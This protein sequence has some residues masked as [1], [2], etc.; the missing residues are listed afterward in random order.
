M[1]CVWPVFAQTTFSLDEKSLLSFGKEKAPQW[2]AIEATFL[3]AKAEALALNDRFRPELFGEAQYSETRERAIIQFMPVW[4]PTES[5][6]VG[7]RQAFRGGVSASAAVGADQRSAMSP[8]GSYRDVSTSTLRL[9]VSIDLWKDLFGKLSKAQSDSANFSAKRAELERD[10][11]RK[12]FGVTLR[13]VYWSMVANNEQLKIYQGLKKI[14][15]D[16]LED[17]RARR[18]AGVTDDGE[19]ARYEAQ[20]ASRQGAF[21]Y[22]NY[23]REILLKQL[24]TLLPELKNHD[25]V[26][27]EYDVSK[28]I[29]TVLACTQVISSQ[30]NVPYQYTQYDEV[31]ELLRKIQAHQHTL[32]KGYDDIDLK[33]VGH[34]KTTGVG[35]ESVGGNNTRG[36]YGAAWD[37]WQDHNRAGY[38]AG[39]QLVIPLGKGDT[40]QT[41]ELVAKKRFDAQINEN[42]ALLTNTHQQLVK[43][44]NILTD[45]VRAQKENTKALEKRM[46]VQNR[47]FREA[48]LSVNDLILDQDALL[49]SNLTT[50]NTQL[51]I[52]NTIL[53]YLVVF[54]ETP[55]EFNRI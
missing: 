30:Q 49:N 44:I 24:R 45:V 9:D 32:A 2:D 22:Y 53:D 13:R 21:L 5:A 46:V 20:V 43:V 42:D 16:Q 23:Q 29:D 8:N 54:T 26:M 19:V 31:T 14:S 47:K 17:A 34:V 35:N 36:S 15:Q 3:S 18:R 27:S 11:N 52:I 40:A 41:Q 39:L 48:R 51:E 37:D 10:I 7:V 55:C 6:Q 33:L 25:V 1:M 12:A 50:V 38:G 4:S 28:M